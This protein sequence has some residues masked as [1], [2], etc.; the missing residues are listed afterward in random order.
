[1][2]DLLTRFW[3]VTDKGYGIGVTGYSELDAR[4]LIAN[5]PSLS[6]AQILKVIENVDVRSIDQG[7]VIPNMGP[8][9]FRG[10]WF[11]NIG[12]A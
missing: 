8:P 11:P 6:D 4:Q 9:N 1:M 3:F 10:I 12:F 2:A 5:E 7:H